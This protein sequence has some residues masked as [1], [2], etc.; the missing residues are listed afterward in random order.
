[1]ILAYSYQDERNKY[2][3]PSEIDLSKKPPVVKAT[4]VEVSEQIEKMSKSKFNVVNPDDIVNEYGADALRLYE[5]YMGPL[6]Q[7]KPWQTDGVRGMHR[8]L[9]RV[10]RLIIGEDGNLHERIQKDATASDEIIQI[11]HKT[12]KRVTED[13]DSMQDRKSTRLN[14]SHVAISYAV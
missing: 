5:M 7:V 11:A 12:T 13:I 2:Y 9:G 4:G 1:M 3:H 14:S 8:F 6:D 10:Y